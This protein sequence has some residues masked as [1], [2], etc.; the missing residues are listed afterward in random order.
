MAL[1]RRLAVAGRWLWAILFVVGTPAAARAELKVF[2]LIGAAVTGVGPY[3]Q[4]VN[5]ALAAF[6]A[7]DRDTA[8]ARLQ[9]AKK[10]T[11]ALA[12]AE[13]MM[14]QL[15]FDAGQNV[16]G[17]GM[18][19]KAR[20]TAPDDPEAY[21][22]LAERAVMDGRLT[23]AD[24]LLPTAEKAVE[25]FNQNPRRKQNMQA[26]LYLAGATL[27][28]AR[29]RLDAAKARLESLIKLDPRNAGSH[30]KLGQVLFA[31][32][33]PKAA[34]SEFQLAAEADERALPAELMMAMLAADKVSAERWISF[35]LKKSPGDLRTQLGAANYFLKN[36]QID[37]A[38]VHAAEA[39]KLDP[40]GFEGN[41]VAGLVAR[42]DGDYANA[43]KYLSTAH[44]QQPGN[45]GVM[46][47]LA[48]VLLESPDAS[49]HERARQ[50]A[51]AVVRQ[52]PDNADFIAALGWINYRL[53]RMAE[54]ERA[55]TA[56]L[57]SK[58]VQSTQMMSSEM[59]YFL[60]NLAK[61]QGNT[62]E[63]MK[64]L[65]ECLNTDQPFAYRKMAEKTLAELAKSSG[66]TTATPAASTRVGQPSP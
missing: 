16:A 20:Q 61:D 35:A 32:N 46:N 62:A 33:E 5:D 7:G 63:A 38:K 11:P 13:V 51:E 42:I 1:F 28:E 36:N 49:N 22:V 53:K 47:H 25:S 21:V 24:L 45:W 50:F 41:F 58:Q 48:L 34:Y 3:V 17:S 37:Q 65:R 39:V 43:E 9:S 54:A 8:L 59:A 52:N 57:K 10:V 29:G 40:D 2:D 19:E 56:V 55:F 18:L 30:S 12:P 4:D 44:L 64:L 6:A 27:D 31:R 14:A 23:E 60:A 26:R 66:D 15:Y